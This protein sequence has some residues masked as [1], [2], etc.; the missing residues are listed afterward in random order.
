MSRFNHKSLE[1]IYE[2]IWTK[3]EMM[4]LQNNGVLEGSEIDEYQNLLYIADF[5]LMLDGRHFDKKFL[6][7]M[8]H[9]LTNEICLLIQRLRVLFP[10]V[11][12]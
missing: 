11:K 7:L 12:E 3:L 1:K 2:N 6:D 4:E 10:K 8:F 5:I 9:R